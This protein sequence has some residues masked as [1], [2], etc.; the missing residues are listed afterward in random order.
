MKPQEMKTEFIR[1]RA[2]G[3]SYSAIADTLSI[4][5][6]TCTAWERELKGEITQLKQE[7]LNELYSAYMMVKESRIKRL[8]DTLQGIED[9]LA[10]ADLT[11]IAPEKLLDF[12]LKYT[13][14]LKEEYTGKGTP[15][16][17]DNGVS[18]GEIVSALGDLY[19]RIRAGDVSAEQAGLEGRALDALLSASNASDVKERVDAL[20]VIISGRGA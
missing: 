1:L 20:D 11:Q 16:T 9:A 17:F 10:E 3:K 6:S 8:G 15:F 13:Q 14:A 19:A 18:P 7:Q 4:S 2:E 5:K 12:K